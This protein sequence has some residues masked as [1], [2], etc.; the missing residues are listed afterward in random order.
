MLERVEELVHLFTVS[1]NDSSFSP[2]GAEKR[3]GHGAPVRPG[4][5]PH[6]ADP[7]PGQQ[8]LVAHDSCGLGSSST[9]AGSGRAGKAVT[10]NFYVENHLCAA[11]FSLLNLPKGKSLG[12]SK[13]ATNS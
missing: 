6:P 4:A 5:A 2:T 9:Q 10:K 1:N 12:R 7:E 11:D 8:P 13:T 3:G